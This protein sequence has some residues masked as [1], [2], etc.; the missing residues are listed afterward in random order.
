VFVEALESVEA[1]RAVNQVL[2]ARG[3][4]SMAN[5]IEGGRT[6]LFDATALQELGFAVVAHPYVW[7]FTAARA[8]QDW[9]VHLKAHGISNGF[10]GRMLDFEVYNALVALDAIRERQAELEG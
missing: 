7:I 3:T 9:A 8:L 2:A 1:M 10:Q 6:P 4:A 5:M